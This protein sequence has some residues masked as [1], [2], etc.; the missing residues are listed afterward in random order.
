MLTL[1]NASSHTGV[2]TLLGF[3]ARAGH[4]LRNEAGRNNQLLRPELGWPLSADPMVWPTV[5]GISTRKLWT[6]LYDLSDTLADGLSPRR[7]EDGHWIIAVAQMA[8]DDDAMGRWANNEAPTEVMT[9]SNI[10]ERWDIL[11]YDVANASLLSGL[12][13]CLSSTCSGFSRWQ[14]RWS[15][16]LNDHHLF[17]DLADAREYA[18]AITQILPTSGPFTPT[19][20]WRVA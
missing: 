6:S 5:P 15:G 19:G 14:K 18:K 9:P 4:T 1:S 8:Q 3:S 16:R 11:G 2:A 10:H 13:N 17:F 20:L 12:T 7:H